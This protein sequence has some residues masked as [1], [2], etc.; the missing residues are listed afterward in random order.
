M[1]FPMSLSL[2]RTIL[3]LQPAPLQVPPELP[4]AP[5]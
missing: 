2:Q 4:P 1:E 5:C 3:P